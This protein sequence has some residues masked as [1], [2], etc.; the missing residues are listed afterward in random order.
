M[1]DAE[2]ASFRS[3]VV[4][5]V[6]LVEASRVRFRLSP[7]SRELARRLLESKRKQVLFDEPGSGERIEVWPL[8]EDFAILEISHR[9]PMSEVADLTMFHR[10][11]VEALVSVLEVVNGLSELVPVTEF[12]ETDPSALELLNPA[13]EAPRRD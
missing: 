2:F 3:R 1:T 6:H 10:M 8:D 9:A 11:H 5:G 13:A 4:D 12:L 7:A